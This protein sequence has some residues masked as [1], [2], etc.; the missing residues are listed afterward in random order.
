MEVKEGSKPE[1]SAYSEGGGGKTYLPSL[2]QKKKKK[3][4]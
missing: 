1:D 3:K 2:G 4:F